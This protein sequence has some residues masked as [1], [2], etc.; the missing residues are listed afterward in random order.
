MKAHRLL[1]FIS[2]M[3]ITVMVAIGCGPS[4]TAGRSTS[5]TV[6]AAASLQ[7]SLEAIAPLFQQV[8]PTIQVKHNFGASGALQQQIRQGAPVDVFISAATRQMDE[9]QTQGLILPETRRPLLAN[10]LVLIVAQTSD[11]NLTDFRQ[12][13][14]ANVRKIAV[15]EPRSVPAGQY[16]EEVFQ[17]LGIAESLKPKFVFANNVRGVLAAVESG[18]AEAGVVYAT[19]AQLSEQVKVVAIAAENL[20]Q[21]IIYPIAVIKE[22]ESLEAAQA[23]IQF[24]SDP[25]AQE[26]FERFGFGIPGA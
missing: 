14:D 19:D 23:Y 5:L 2:L 24:L 8:H 17:A 13:A 25:Q 21:P 6:S 11:L 15:G 18:N 20:H 3:I 4:E 9:L 16:A 12:L 7:E 22:S 1:T 10:R 26:I